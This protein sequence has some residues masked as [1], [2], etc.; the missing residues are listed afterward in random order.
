M[1]DSSPIKTEIA[2]KIPWISG[3]CIVVVVINDDRVT[4][5]ELYLPRS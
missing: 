4:D 3:G 1:M 5:V 2:I